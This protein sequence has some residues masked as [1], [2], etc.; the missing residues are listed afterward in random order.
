MEKLHKIFTIRITITVLLI[1]CCLSNIISAQSRIIK[2]V[3]NGQYC[4]HN[5]ENLVVLRP[6]VYNTAVNDQLGVIGNDFFGPQLLTQSKNDNDWEKTL[7]PTDYFTIYRPGQKMT[8]CGKVL[9][10]ELSDGF[11]DD[12]LNIQIVCNP[13]NPAFEPKYM[14]I[15]N[16][17]RNLYPWPMIEGEIDI[18]DGFHKFFDPKSS[19]F[20]F[21]TVNKTDICLY[22]PWVEEVYDADED[23]NP[24]KDHPDVH[25]IHPAEQFW[26]IEKTTTGFRYYLNAANDGS[27]RFEESGWISNESKNTF[28]IA[29]DIRKRYG[30]KLIYQLTNVCSQGTTP[31]TADGKKHYL[32]LG[33]DTLIQVEEPAGADIVSVSFAEVGLDPYA[34]LK[35]QT[36]SVIK[37]FI[38][39]QSKIKNYTHGL[40]HGNLKLL[41]DKKIVARAGSAMLNFDAALQGTTLAVPIHKKVKVTLKEIAT[42][43]NS[44]KSGLIPGSF[45]LTGYIFAGKETGDLS[46]SRP[47][48]AI[49]EDKPQLLFPLSPDKEN[50]RVIKHNLGPTGIGLKK[51]TY[52]NSIYINISPAEKISILTDFE[53]SYSGSFIRT[54]ELIDRSPFYELKVGL[55][56]LQKNIPL[57]KEII[58]DNWEHNPQYDP[59]KY[60]M[61]I[62]LEFLL[63]E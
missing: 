30:G 62:T 55:S 33:K 57:T 52:Y 10:Q 28:A 37:G 1:N 56:D 24:L 21:P 44:F 61:K 47:T 39:L 5:I 53:A 13:K 27:G 9:Q 38:V 22:G 15:K 12:D 3:V 50:N 20:K 29:F 34:L 59:K 18:D 40:E 42:L 31:Q 7:T 58:L 51:T 17:G 25:E 6:D 23:V 48:S 26:W 14:Q 4:K 2:Q 19:G 54:L 46:F 63:M 45:N 35:D 41:V 32:L 11:V 49:L 43:E 16:R 8:F 60:K 36:D